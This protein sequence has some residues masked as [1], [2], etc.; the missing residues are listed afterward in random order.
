MAL[1]RLITLL[2]CSG[3]MIVSSVSSAT[4]STPEPRDRA[5]LPYYFNTDTLGNTVGVAGVMK[6]IG[7]PQAGLFGLGLYSDKKSHISLL[8]AFDYAL[9]DSWLFNGQVYQ[10]RLN[11]SPYYVDQQGG[12]DSAITD[13]TLT[14]GRESYAEAEFRYLLPWGSVASRGLDAAFD[15]RRDV[16]FG[17][18]LETGISSVIVKPFY[19]YRKL[20]SLSESERATGVSIKFDWDNRDVKQNP[21]RG[22][23]SSLDLTLGGDEWRRDRSWWKWELQ[24]SQY[25][26]LGPLGQTLDQQVIAFDF[27]A[28]DT[29]SWADCDQQTC[30]L[31]PEQEQVRLG[32]LYRLRGYTAGR[33][34]GRSAIHYSLEYRAT[35]RWQPLND[36]PV[37]NYYHFGW[38]QWV[39]F[40]EIGRVSNQ[41]D[42]A[43]L[44][45]D[46]RWTLGG[47][48]RF[49]VEGITVRTEMATSADEQSLVVMI[50]QPF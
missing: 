18:P 41:A 49:Q 10:A 43:Q 7:Q 32:G 34:H 17:S 35:P 16:Q 27:Y 20:A 6:G 46:M 22:S 12:N 9:G 15:H 42:W 3:L 33:Y 50:N 30:T 45:K 2:L 1:L 14:D 37:I 47:G 44:H 23:H 36:I 5:L 24:T 38:W 8:A 4:E 25:Y 28:A 48:I 40:A 21:T 11:K 29:P 19:T 31:P 26:A 13:L 39:A